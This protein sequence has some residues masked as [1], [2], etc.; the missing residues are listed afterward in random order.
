MS[1]DKRFIDAFS[2][3]RSRLMVFFVLI[4]GFFWIVAM[5]YLGG[6]KVVS[7]RHALV[8][9]VY[10][11][12]GETAPFKGWSPANPFDPA[13]YAARLPSIIFLIIFIYIC[14]C[15]FESVFRRMFQKE[16]RKV[17]SNES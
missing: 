12:F 6:G 14:A 16:K 5:A 4:V 10:E 1:L 2:P 8:N 11:Y 13:V 7:S 17:G 15:F 3:T 9:F